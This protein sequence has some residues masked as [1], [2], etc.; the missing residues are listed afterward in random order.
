MKK[1]KLLIIG[2]IMISLS[3][4]FKDDSM[5]NINIITSVYP[6]EYVVNTL[7]GDH[8]NIQSIYPIDSE[9]TNFK[10]TDTLL[11][12]YSKSDLFIFN[13][14]SKEKEYIKKLNKHNNNLKIIDGTSNMVYDYK[15]EELWLDPGNLLTIANNIKKGFKEYIKSKY[16]INE[17][18]ENYDSLKIALTGLDGKYYS[19]AKKASNLNIIVSNDSFKYL[20]KYGINIISLDSD[21]TTD[22]DKLTAEELINN[23]KCKYIYIGYKEELNNNIKEFIENNNIKTVE[24]YTLTNLYGIDTNK[25]DYITLMNQNLDNLKLELYN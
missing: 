5:D 2:L 16:L 8:S 20:E 6:I 17:I 11:E 12:N 4:C 3:G 19:T 24:L 25:T 14:L 10:V 7:Y 21:S 18:E 22:K 13:G 1:I 23:G 9:A 15:M